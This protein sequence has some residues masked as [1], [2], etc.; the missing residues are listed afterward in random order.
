MEF[1]VKSEVTYKSNDDFEMTNLADLQRAIISG[2]VE[3][4]VKRIALL[5]EDGDEL[6]NSD[7]NPEIIEGFMGVITD[8]EEAQASLVF[9]FLQP[10]NKNMP[11]NED[12]YKQQGD[13]LNEI[14]NVMEII[15]N[16]DR[17]LVIKISRMLDYRII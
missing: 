7:D 14:F 12:V 16:S 10:R 3:I 15:I 4:N 5:D 6:V 1:T 17:C 13:V 8:T 9:F 11:Y 2:E